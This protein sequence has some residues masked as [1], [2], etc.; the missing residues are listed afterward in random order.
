MKKTEELYSS[1]LADILNITS[2]EDYFIYKRFLNML[3]KVS[4]NNQNIFSNLPVYSPVIK[5]EFSE[6][7]VSIM[8]SGYRIIIENK[9]NGASD[10]PNQLARYIDGSVNGAHY[11]EKDIYIVYIT[12][13][14]KSPSDHS[15]IRPDEKFIPT[16]Y[17]DDFKQHFVNITRS[18]IC[19]WL[20]QDIT[21]LCNDKPEHC[22]F[23][24]MALKYF[25][26]EISKETFNGYIFDRKSDESDASYN[27]QEIMT[28]WAQFIEWHYRKEDIYNVKAT[29]SGIEVKFNRISHGIGEFGC[30]VEIFP[31]FD[32]YKKSML[33]YGIYKIDE[34]KYF[35]EDNLKKLF[36][37]F[38]VIDRYYDRYNRYYDRNN[39]LHGF[40]ILEGEGDWLAYNTVQLWSCS[41]YEFKFAF[42]YYLLDLI[43]KIIMFI[44]A[45]SKVGLSSPIETLPTSEESV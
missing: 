10:Q 43:D 22:E 41:D 9:I 12:N 45:P 40:K 3:D 7:D 38:F 17:K 23:V 1:I 11:L 30:R 34:N 29:A 31:D 35:T 14:K 19:A 5:A 39:K 32:G 21:V 28:N 4:Q 25:K 36:K 33:R 16:D 44:I 37:L 42:K 8:D 6:V 2:Q 24:K 15:W 18:D 27:I 26:Q 13:D 20:E